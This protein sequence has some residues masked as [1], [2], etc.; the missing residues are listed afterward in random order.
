MYLFRLHLSSEYIAG[1]YPY[2]IMEHPRFCENVESS[3]FSSV[4]RLLHYR[5]PVNSEDMLLFGA[6]VLSW[7]GLAG[8]DGGLELS[9][10]DPSPPFFMC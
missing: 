1:R 8:G 5:V 10:G 2:L 4:G 6:W 7:S 9:Q 3:V